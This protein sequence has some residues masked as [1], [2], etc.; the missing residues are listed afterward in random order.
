M[1]P[2]SKENWLVSAIAVKQI[3]KPKSH[4]CQPMIARVRRNDRS[5][6]SGGSAAGVIFSRLSAH[7]TRMRCANSL[8]CSIYSSTSARVSALASPARYTGRRSRITSRVTFICPPPFIQSCAIVMRL[9]IRPAR[10]VRDESLLSPP[11]E[12]CPLL[13]RSLH[14]PFRQPR[15]SAVLTGWPPELF[16]AQPLRKPIFVSARLAGRVRVVG[17]AELHRERPDGIYAA[18]PGETGC[19]RSE[20]K[21]LSPLP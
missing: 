12:K 9:A 14:T 2:F 5:S 15:A 11:Q 20:K 4:F 7:C 21:S 16:E 10:D 17:R 1:R 6:R 13:A 3:P 19:A 8:S 18:D